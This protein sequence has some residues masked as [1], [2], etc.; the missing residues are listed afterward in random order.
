MADFL[1]RPLGKSLADLGL[2]QASDAVQ[3]AGRSLPCS[4]AS[5][6]S[7][8]IVT[9][10]FE[11]DAAPF[12]LPNVT[13]PVFMSRYVR[14]PLQVGDRG[15]A[16]AADARLGVTSGLGTGTPDLS[17]PA[18]LSALMFCPS[19]STAW[20]SVDLNAVV[21]TGPNGFVL[22]DDS[23]ATKVTG[24][25]SDLKMAQGANSVETNGAGTK[26]TGN[27]GFFGGAPAAKQT[28]TGAISAVTDPA[29]KA[30]L[31]SI[32]TALGLST[33]MTNSTT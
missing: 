31:L 14:L 1:K 33:L 10:K 29:A 3:L 9:I 7:S 11:V 32:A 26:I 17:Q 2:K 12:T 6:V 13:V 24:T 4:V 8:G 25:P 16:F 28:I 15:V 21:I 22:Q 20:T 5:V 23:G 30:A 19:G 18:N 27:A